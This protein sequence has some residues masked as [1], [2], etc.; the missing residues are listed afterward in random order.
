MHTTHFL[1]Q[2][3]PQTHWVLWA[4]ASALGQYHCCFIHSGRKFSESHPPKAPAELFQQVFHLT[5]HGAALDSH[6][7]LAHCS[8]TAPALLTHH[9]HSNSTAALFQEAHQIIKSERQLSIA[10]RSATTQSAVSMALRAFRLMGT[11]VS[12]VGGGSATF[13]MIFAMYSVH[14]SSSRVSWNSFA[15][16]QMLTTLSSSRI[17]AKVL[18]HRRLSPGNR[19]MSATHSTS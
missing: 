15:I 18:P 11:C 8:D 13:S 14:W 16:L 10:H 17:C 7:H 19:Y 9:V 5:V 2:A 4:A 3:S 1:N 12:A 6:Q